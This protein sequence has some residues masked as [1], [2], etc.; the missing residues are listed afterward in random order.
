MSIQTAK[1]QE[2]SELLE[3]A[4]D[5]LTALDLMGDAIGEKNGFAISAVAIAANSAAGGALDIIGRM[6]SSGGGI[7][8]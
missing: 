5:L 8:E 6:A 7:T 4:I 1:L 2:A 3:E